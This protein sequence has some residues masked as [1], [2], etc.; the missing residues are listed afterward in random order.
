MQGDEGVLRQV[1]PARAAAL[2]RVDGWMWVQLR[3]R[4]MR[5][6]SAPMACR[7]G[8][9]PSAMT[10]MAA[11][12]RTARASRRVVSVGNAIAAG[13]ARLRGGQPH[14]VLDDDA[15]GAVASFRPCSRQERA[16][17]ARRDADGEVGWWHAACGQPI[18]KEGELI[19]T[20]LGGG[21]P[22]RH[23]V[24]TAMNVDRA[25]TLIA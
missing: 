2:S 13:R 12:L 7:C 15:V 4:W 22:A 25:S 16:G 6:R 20:A 24:A 5:P 9:K 8:R 10:P 17:Q 23:V 11:A 3:M 1:E 18:C 21:W 14:E 19:E